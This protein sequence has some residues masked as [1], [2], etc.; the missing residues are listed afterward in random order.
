[1]MSQPSS[2]TYIRTGKVMGSGAESN[3]RSNTPGS[4]KVVRYDPGPSCN[5]DSKDDMN[6]R[7]G[8]L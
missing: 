5:A 4:A 7:S 1:M 2:A 3:R 6:S 8:I